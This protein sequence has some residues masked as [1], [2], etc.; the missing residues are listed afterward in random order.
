MDALSALDVSTTPFPHHSSQCIKR[1][2]TTQAGSVSVCWSYPSLQVGQGA[3]EVPAQAPFHHLQEKDGTCNLLKSWEVPSCCEHQAFPL[4]Q[5]V[6]HVL[7][8]KLHWLLE[9][10]QP[11]DSGAGPGLCFQHA[12]LACSVSVNFIHAFRHGWNHRLERAWCKEPWV[13]LNAFSV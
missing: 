7:K 3:Q 6:R 4:L 5:G 8:H 13:S 9:A 10:H 1:L 2:V 12:G 11:A